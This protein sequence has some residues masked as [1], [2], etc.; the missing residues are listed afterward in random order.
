MKTILNRDF[1][2]PSDGWYHIEPMGDHPNRPAG[3]VQVIDDTSVQSIVN[4]F[5]AEADKPGFPGMLIDHEHFKHDASKASVAYGWLMKVQNRWD[6]VYGQIRWTTTGKAAVDGGDYRFFSTEYNGTD[7]QVLNHGKPARL[8]PLRLAGL[9]LTNDPNNKGSRPI[10]NRR[11]HAPSAD[12]PVTSPSLAAMRVSMLINRARVEEGFSRAMAVSMIAQRQPAMFRLAQDAPYSSENF[13]SSYFLNR[14][15]ATAEKLR[16]I[17]NRSGYLDG[18]QEFEALAQQVFDG[19]SEADAATQSLT[20]TNITPLF[21]EKMK[22]ARAA[23][24][25]DFGTAWNFVR[26]N[27]PELFAAYV[28]L[29]TS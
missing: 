17:C 20:A 11:T 5:N 1:E 19:Q 27:Y 13:S 25:G 15:M 22:Q 28:T 6:G 21:Q 8:R 9:T 29:K 18:N 7:M 23:L 26:E 2:H 4:R 3:I 10:T 14:A 16:A 24:Q 12:E